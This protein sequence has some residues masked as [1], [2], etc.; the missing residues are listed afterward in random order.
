MKQDRG[1]QRSL[2][3]ETARMDGQAR[4]KIPI[5]RRWRERPDRETLPFPVA[6][7][8]DATG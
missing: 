7:P 6:Q 2:L 4:A 5:R 8:N 1:R 3:P